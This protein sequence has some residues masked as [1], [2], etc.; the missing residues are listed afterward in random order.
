MLRSTLLSL[1]VFALVVLGANTAAAQPQP[2]L[3]ASVLSS[4]ATPSTSSDYLLQST[5]GQRALGRLSNTRFVLNT[6]F[7]HQVKPAG[8]LVLPVANADTVTT[9]ED[10]AVTINVLANDTDPAGGALSI[11]SFTEPSNGTLEQAGDS[12]LT[13]TPEADFNGLDAFTYIVGND[14]GGSAQGVVTVTIRA[15]NDAPRFISDPGTGAAVG[16]AYSYTAEATDVEGDAVA[17]TAPTLPAWLSFTDHG[18][19]TATLEGTPTS[20]EVGAHAVTLAASDGSLSQEQS[21]TI[22]V[23]ALAAPQLVAPEDGAVAVPTTVRLSWNAV[24]G[25]ATY[26]VQVDTEAGFEPPVAEAPGLTVTEVEVTVLA[27]TTTYYWR[28]R[29]VGDAGPGPYAEAF[30]FTTAMGVAVE[31]EAVVPERFALLQNYPNPFNPTTTIAYALPVR[32]EVRLVVYDLYGREVAVLVETTQAAGRY[33]VQVE[34]STLASGVY[35]YRLTAGAFTE[36]KAM[37]LLK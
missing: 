28:V 26:D 20:A 2:V 5:L 33:A 10:V 19:G 34:A 18:D 37:T 9:D 6:G 29:A 22:T 30:H 12:T 15:V 24:P 14:Q 16:T 25:A 27:P 35:L 3:R 23:S 1:L 13:Y 36:T 21:F 4:G 8:L 31:E 32:A 17:I 11:S 7:W